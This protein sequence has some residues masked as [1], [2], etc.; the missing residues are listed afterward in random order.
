VAIDSEEEIQVPIINGKDDAVT[1]YSSK[2]T[3]SKAATPSSIGTNF[4][5]DSGK[6]SGG[7][8][9][10][11]KDNK[12]LDDELDRYHYIREILEDIS[13]EL[14]AVGKAKDRAFGAA[15][16]K[17]MDKEIALL[18]KQAAA[19]KQYIKEIEDYHAQD[20]KALA[21]YGATFDE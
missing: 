20:R 7:S 13:N 19:E 2:A 15:K 16:L 8:E 12:A 21:E 5:K 9:R 1:G 18:Q 6:S 17:N 3:F 11:P 14:D 4:A 10:S